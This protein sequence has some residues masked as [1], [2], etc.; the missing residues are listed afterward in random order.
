[1]ADKFVIDY[2]GILKALPHRYPFLLVDGV[3]A[4]QKG[5]AAECQRQENDA[6]DNQSH[7]ATRKHRND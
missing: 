1:M 7:R 4:F 2:A 3:L 6:V 5:K